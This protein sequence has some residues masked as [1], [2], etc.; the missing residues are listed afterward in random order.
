MD[1]G[2]APNRAVPDPCVSSW[3]VDRVHNGDP[4]NPVSTTVGYGFGISTAE[5]DGTWNV[6]PDRSSLL[7][8]P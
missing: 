7:R 3:T 2:F 8:T 6:G 1:G 4:Q 5:A